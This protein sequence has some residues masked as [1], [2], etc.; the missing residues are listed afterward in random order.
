MFPK[1]VPHNRQHTFVNENPKGLLY[2]PA[3]N[4]CLQS[5]LQTQFLDRVL[6][7]P[8]SSWGTYHQQASCST[9]TLTHSLESLILDPILHQAIKITWY[10]LMWDSIHSFIK[11]FILIVIQ[12]LLWGQK[13][14]K[15]KVVALSKFWRDDDDTY[16][17]F[18]LCT[19]VTFLRPCLVA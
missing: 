10:D 6:R 12:T 15:E 4:N 9:T 19:A 1:N 8:H 5:W 14:N 3:C 2:S 18:A 11:V 13:R 7:L 17:M 16:M